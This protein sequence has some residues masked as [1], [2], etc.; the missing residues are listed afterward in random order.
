[1]H[2][3]YI[4]I[5]VMLIR[6]INICRNENDIMI[7][8]RVEKNVAIGLAWGAHSCIDNFDKSANF[9]KFNLFFVFIKWPNC[10]ALG[11]FIV[12]LNTV[13]KNAFQHA[14]AFIPNFILIT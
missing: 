12:F 1:M 3:L 5:L 11:H 9:V 10:I 6:I 14:V 2:I 4:Y 13:K 8:N 7:K